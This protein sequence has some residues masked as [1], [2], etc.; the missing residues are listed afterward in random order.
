[1]GDASELAFEA[2]V[3]DIDEQGEAAGTGEMPTK[4]KRNRK[5]GGA[6]RP[7]NE[8]GLVG[9]GKRGKRDGGAEGGPSTS[10]A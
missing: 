8:F 1:M 3:S 5:R 10:S 6:G 4:K 9:V 2:D 7:R